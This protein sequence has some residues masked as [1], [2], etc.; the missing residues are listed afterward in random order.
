MELTLK[1][2]DEARPGEKLRSLFEEHWPSYE[3]WFQ[4]ESEAA[5]P[6]YL[7]CRRKVEQC[8][9]ELFPLWE[10]FV[11]T[12][13]GGGDQEARF[14]S[15]YRPPPYIQGCSQA[16]WT[17]EESMLVR[18]YDYAPQLFEGV[19][20][21]SCWHERT[22]LAM[23]DC[24]IGALDGIND[25]GLCVSL[26]FGGRK[27]VG[28][29]F[30]API[31]VRYLLEFCTT[32]EEAKE[33]LSGLRTHMSYSL[34]VLDRSGS[35]ITA[36]LRPDGDTVFRQIP[37]STNH[38]DEVEWRRHAE[39]TATIERQ[40]F[41][42][43]RL[44]SLDETLDGFVQSFLHP[45]LR[46]TQYDRGFGTLYTATYDPVHCAATYYWPVVAWTQ[47]IDSFDEGEVTITIDE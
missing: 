41:M 37:A 42:L 19:V 21:K 13:G 9:P 25:A 17:G 1:A 44:S 6:T 32:V 27:V 40:Q 35:F 39:A 22:V 14:L 30:G 7:E 5:R 2:I 47:T 18:N 29:G 4:S 11:Q 24:L 28:D 46:S 31:I 10:E 23:T 43:E 34:L 3:R 12:V 36:F 33:K 16:V 20:L 8:L 15:L 38:Q 26:N 45:P